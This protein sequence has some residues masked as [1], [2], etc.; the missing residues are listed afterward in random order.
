MNESLTGL[1]YSA[2]KYFVKDLSTLSPM[3][4]NFS[5]SE[6]V[7]FN[8]QLVISDDI[9]GKEF[10]GMYGTLTNPS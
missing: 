3:D 4:A 5:E 8:G 2:Y 6:K 10:F 9:N 1:G 7:G